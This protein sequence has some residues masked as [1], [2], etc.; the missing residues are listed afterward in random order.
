MHNWQR[1]LLVELGYQPFLPP[2]KNINPTRSPAKTLVAE[3][4]TPDLSAK[5]LGVP[6]HPPE[7]NPYQR[8]HTVKTLVPDRP[9]SQVSWADL[10]LSQL[11]EVAETCSQCAL[12]QTRKNVVFGAG[13]I[14]DGSRSLDLLIVGEAPGEMEDLKA[15]PFVGPSG[16]LLDHI[17]SSLQINKNSSGKYTCYITNAVKCRPPHNR[18]PNEHEIVCCQSYLTRQISLLKPKV[19][20]ALGV[21][22]CKSL[23]AQDSLKNLPL[24]KLRGALH[25]SAL[26][27]AMP[28]L[29]SY[30]PAYLLRN[31]A[32][33]HWAWEDFCN[34]VELL[35]NNPSI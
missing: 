11:R 14:P 18:S 27:P 21:I 10:T 16:Q 26:A 9:S 19:V 1:E 15:E 20:L 32:E 29:V 6:R 35:E 7:N 34:L 30:H 2:I 8:I 31:P 3:N 25:E 13:F 28:I 33:K 4:R 17:L 23:L 12:A 5:N 24:K 22:A